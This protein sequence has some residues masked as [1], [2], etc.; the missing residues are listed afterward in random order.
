MIGFSVAWYPRRAHKRLLGFGLRKLFTRSIDFVKRCREVLLRARGMDY[1]SS[2]TLSIYDAATSYFMM[3]MICCT[4]QMRGGDLSLGESYNILRYLEAY[5]SNSSKRRYRNMNKPVNHIEQQM[6]RRIYWTIFVCSRSALTFAKGASDGEEVM[7]PETPTK[8]HPPLPMDTDDEF[9]THD[10]IR[11]SSK[12]QSRMAGFNKN[13]RI[14]FTLDRLIATELSYG[15]ERAYERERQQKTILEC[16]S[17]LD[18]IYAE[19][20][21]SLAHED[22]DGTHAQNLSSGIRLGSPEYI[23]RG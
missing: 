6:A 18:R 7:G 10:A 20:P 11:P 15:I 21:D 23:E 16:L 3:S 5:K 4:Y 8:P 14:F 2:P 22:Q 19:L 12:P 1:L 13:A 17:D 9:I